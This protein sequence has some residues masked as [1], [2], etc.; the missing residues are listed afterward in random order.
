MGD[1]EGDTKLVIN[2]I[3]RDDC[4]PCILQYQLDMERCTLKEGDCSRSQLGVQTRQWIFIQTY[5]DELILS[6]NIS[7]T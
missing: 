4:L 7:H 6:R 1:I 3:T 2:A 5:I